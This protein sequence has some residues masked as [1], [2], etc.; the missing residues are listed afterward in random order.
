M[1]GVRSTH[2][3]HPE[4]PEE[5]AVKTRPIAEKWEPVASKLY[6]E[7]PEK[8]KRRFGILTKVMFWGNEK[9]AR[10]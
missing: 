2:L 1:D 3:N 10:W 9:I 5:L 7:M 8:E 6:D 4:T